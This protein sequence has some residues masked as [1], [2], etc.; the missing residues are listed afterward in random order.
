MTTLSEADVRKHVKVNIEKWLFSGGHIADFHLNASPEELKARLGKYHEGTLINRSSSF[1]DM[2][3]GDDIVTGLSDGIQSRAKKIKNWV[4]HSENGILALYFD[5]L[6]ENVSGIVCSIYREGIYAADGYYAILYKDEQY[7][8]YL[9]NAYPVLHLC[10]VYGQLKAAT[11]NAIRLQ[12]EIKF[13]SL[14]SILTHCCSLNS[15]DC[16]ISNC[17]SYLSYLFYTDISSSKYSRNFCLHTFI[18]WNIYV[19]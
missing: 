4:E 17:C 19:I 8:F 15:C 13:Q 1:L 16:A 12:A 5:H 9:L 3:G 10:F 14:L 7:P 2:T 6:P 18:H 11:E